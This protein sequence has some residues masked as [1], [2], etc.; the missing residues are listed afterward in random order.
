MACFNSFLVAAFLK[1]WKNGLTNDFS[2]AATSLTAIQILSFQAVYEHL[3]LVRY[4][5]QLK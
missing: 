1:S 4:S 5:S 3:L 2:S